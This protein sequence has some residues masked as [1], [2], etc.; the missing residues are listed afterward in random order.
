LGETNDI[1]VREGGE[2]VDEGH[3]VLESAIQPTAAGERTVRK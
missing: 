3:S 2:F 1:G